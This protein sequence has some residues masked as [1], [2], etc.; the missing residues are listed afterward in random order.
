MLAALLTIALSTTAHARNGM[1]WGTYSHDSAHG[2]DTVG[3]SAGGVACNA[4]TGDTSCRT[5]LPVLCINVDGSANPGT[6]TSTYYSWAYGNIATTLPIAGTSLTSLATADAYCAK[7][8]G[9]GWR[10]AEFH[11]GWGWGFVANGHVRNDT[12]Y[13]VQID[14]QPADCWE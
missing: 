5:S 6:P 12:R 9:T 10:M 2:T 4:Y 7:S 13:W 1:T 11:D 8:F 3:C 14:D